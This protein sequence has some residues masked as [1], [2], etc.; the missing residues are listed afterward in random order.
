[1]VLRSLLYT[2]H[3]LLVQEVFADQPARATQGRHHNVDLAHA[4]IA[5]VRVAGI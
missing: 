4:G 3:N 5:M 1:M 2:A